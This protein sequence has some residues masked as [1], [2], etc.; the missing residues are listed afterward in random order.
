MMFLATASDQGLRELL[1]CVGM[2]GC[3]GG[4]DDTV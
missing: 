3:G 1:G 4:D 2:D